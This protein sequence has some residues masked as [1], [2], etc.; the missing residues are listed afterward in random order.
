MSSSNEIAP[1]SCFQVEYLKLTRFL[2]AL[3]LGAGILLCGTSCLSASIIHRWS[4]SEAS[5]TNI[6]DSIGTANGK[7]V[8]IGTNTDYSRLSGMVRLAGGTRAQAD[9][10][11]LPSGL[12]HSLTNV[13]IELWATPRVGQIWSRIFDFGPGN[14]T[15]AG[16]FFLSFCRGS[17]SLNQQ[18]FEFGS[19]A[20]WTV[21]T[22][23]A[24]TVSN[25]Y[26]YVVTW[27]ANGA[28]DGGGL[29]QWFRDGVL[30]A[31]TNTGAMSIANINDTVL[32]LGR[33]QFTADA[34]ATADYNEVRIYSHAMSPTEIF[35]SKTNGPDNLI[36]PPPAASNLSI[37]T[38]AGST[39]QLSW[40]PGAGST[41]S[42]IV[43]A[44]GQPPTGQ[45]TNGV[46][47]SASAAFGSGQN[48]GASNFVVYAG[49][50]NTIIVSNLT[51][52][53][54]YYAAV[55]SYSGSG[56][57]LI[58]NL[59]D[60]PIASQI[61]PGAAQ[62]ISLQVNSQILFTGTSQATVLANFGGGLT[63]DVTT[64]ATYV[65]SAP[66]VIT[67]SSNGV[68]HAV[69]VGS[70][71]ITA[72]YQSQQASNTVTVINPLVNN[73]THRYSFTL[74]A[75]DSVAGADGRLQN[76]ASIFS[77]QVSLDGAGGFVNLPNDLV[78]GYASI[79][80]ET[81]VTD[82]GSGGWARIFDFGNS[83]G[84]E[85]GQGTGTQYMFLALPAPSGGNN[86]RGAYTLNGGGAEQLL[87][88][89]GGGRPAVGQEAHIVWTTD[90]P[91]H[92]GFLYVNGVLVASNLN[93]TLTPAAI[94]S[95]FNDWLG[96]SQFAGDAYFNGSIDEF[97]IYN[98]ALP[99]S[100]V[101]TNF[102]NGPNGLTVPPPVA[103]DDAMTL[104][105][106]ALAL[107]PVLQ[108]DQGQQIDPNSVT[109][110]SSP[111]AGTAQ[112]KPGG[113]ILYVNNG[114]PATSDQ[115]T[116]R[117][118]NT[119][120]D[121]SEV[122]TV[123]ITITNTL[124]LPNTTIT[125]PNTPPPTAYQVVDAFP[126]LT[127]TQPLAMRTPA[128]AAYSNLLFVVERRGLITYIDVTA[129]N[130]T[131]QI[132]LN[133]SNQVAF[134]TSPTDGELGMLSMDFHPG[135]ATN[136]IFFVSY[137]APG[138]VPY[139]DRV[140]RFTADP[141]ALTVNTN[142]QQVLYSMPDREFNH[143]GSDL[144]FGLDGYLY[145]SVGDE[146][147][148]YNVHMNAQRLDLNLFSG[149]LR[150]DTDKRPG[151]IEPTPNAGIPTDGSGHA[152]YSIPPDNP[153]LGVTNLY[154]TPV[155]QATLR[156]EFYAI[157]FRH[158]WRFSI[159]PA[160]GEIWVGDVGQDR[161]EEVDILRKGGNYGWPYYEATH[162]TMTNYPTQP[163]MLPPPTNYVM[164][165]PLWEYPHTAVPGA[166][167]KF[168]GLDVNGSL[169]YHGSRIP[170][171]TNAYLFGDFDA[172][173][174]IWALHRLTN[175]TVSVERLAGMPGIAAFGADPHNGDLLMA[176]YLQ[177]KLQRLVNTDISGS[178][179]PTKLSDTGI[180]ADLATLTPNPGVINYEPIIA[181]WSDYAVKRRWFCIPDMTN[182]VTYATDANWLFPSGMMW[183]KHFDLETTRGNPATKKRI[184]TRVIVKNNTGA[185][186]VSYGW[187]PTGTE[188]YLVPDAGTNFFITVQDGTNTI[189]QQ[190]EI[191]SRSSCLACHTDAGGHVLSWNTRELNQ[192]TNMNGFTGNQLTL[193]SLAGYLD[194]SINTP[195]TLPSFATATNEAYS[196]EYRARSYFAM[197]C[198]QCHQPG[199][200]GAPS[201][202]ARPWLTLDQTHLINGQPADVG[203]DPANRLIVPG[204]T[205]HSVVLQRILGNGFSRMPPLATHQLDLGA[206]NLLTAWITIG[207]TNQTFADW[208]VAHFGSTNSPNA[209]PNADPDGDRI[210]NF[211]EYLTG[212]DPQNPNS[213][214]KMTITSSAGQINLSYPRVPNLGVVIDTSSNLVT[215][216]PWDVPGNQPFF[217]ATTGTTSLYSPNTSTS[218]F[219][220]ARFVLP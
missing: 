37:T 46:T 70:A 39:L 218:Q 64:A 205:A 212:T 184:E 141:V 167:P 27:S 31:S 44:A 198:V 18:R 169:V 14:N 132:F 102:Q 26:H 56:P 202:D 125:I 106:G 107:I 171:L 50:G 187:D 28:S 9:Y 146:G 174:N 112:A 144:H 178:G 96:K 206:S 83:T 85:D 99:P 78:T 35:I 170:A 58:Y 92:S 57:S 88:W 127:F 122:A 49:S 105:P 163:G 80:L 19:P 185:Y 21:D 63:Q 101:V 8:V 6:I 139:F 175:N 153:F 180:F 30:Q 154:G 191:P 79:T 204:D 11:E 45:P 87:Q 118:Q 108:N 148:Q 104:N 7:I 20:S 134:D 100:L 81:W 137:I 190:W 22:G 188:A 159:D 5:G 217:A 182:A 89:P 16:T 119:Q 150:I 133:I 147:G 2:R 194:T 41:G 1:P 210:N 192:T 12:V 131:K 196:L 151:S 135:F 120:G 158:P 173:G 162:L 149:I 15:Q 176:N 214:W 155:N 65:S 76:G 215:W 53:A 219:F 33:S 86:L 54:R 95:T 207:L 3:C 115:F 98:V 111:T 168:S 68:L 200:P 117:I 13:T 42:L 166:D 116:Y 129:P 121:T 72:S 55:Y 94:G 143:N 61:V 69:G 43:M 71:S 140:A 17:T 216:T 138:G 36:I 213:A 209:A 48:L 126:G 77:G 60:P 32:W 136:G 211:L 73:L 186:G 128:G 24:T 82:N 29:A 177:N 181:F 156:G 160:T 110:M 195:Q 203:G 193:L 199:G 179:F 189:Q 164:D 113:K 114:G 165:Y 52:G 142:T 197:N 124:R 157:G 161:W 201:W 220:R 67:V 75:S 10:I 130:P 51:P 93:M 97:R 59:A 103:V 40:T 38:N 152:F 25:Q 84:G 172:G 123:S 145:I 109:L 91:T 183:I 66:N 90:G 208:Q 34:S 74:D 47:Y 62:S 4:F 23:T